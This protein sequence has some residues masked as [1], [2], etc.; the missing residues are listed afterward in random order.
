MQPSNYTGY[1]WNS[2]LEKSEAETVARN[3]MTI[4]KRTGDTWRELTWEEYKTE[5][6]KDGRFSE[7]EQG[8]YEQVIPYCK[9]ADTANL[10]CKNWVK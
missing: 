10:F 6:L 5:R 4:L 2:V 3:I 9:S 8:Y 1:P 7:M